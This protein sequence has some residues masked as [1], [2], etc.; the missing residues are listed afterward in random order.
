MGSFSFNNAL[1]S[2]HYASLCFHSLLH[3]LKIFISM[4][5][6]IP[7]TMQ[8]LHHPAEAIIILVLTQQKTD[9]DSSQ[10]SF[11]ER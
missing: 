10:G 6:R 4:L 3:L 5:K 2:L 1:L 11:T 7:S 9:L 8:T